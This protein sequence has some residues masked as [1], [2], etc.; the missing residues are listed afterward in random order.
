MAEKKTEIAEDQ[1]Q[2]NPVVDEFLL[3]EQEAGL[4]IEIPDVEDPDSLGVGGGEYVPRLTV[5]AKDN[6]YYITKSYGGLNECILGSP[7]YS[8]GSALNNCVGYAWGR[9]YELLG[10][11]PKL[12]RANAEDWW[13]Y[14]DG[15]KRGQVPKLGAIACWRKGKAG[16][17]ADGAGHVAVCEVIEG[18]NWKAGQSGYGASTTFWLTTYKTGSESHGAYVFQGFIYIDDWEEKPVDPPAPS[19]DLK[20][21]DIVSFTGTKHYSSAN[22]TKAATTKPGPAKVTQL[23]PSGKH[24][25][26]LIHTDSTSN[27]YGWVDKADIAGQATPTPEPWTPKVG[28]VVIYN[29]VTHYTNANAAN[30]KRCKG[31]KAV[32]SRIYKLGQSK[33]PYLL[34][35]VAGSGATVYGWVDTGTFTKA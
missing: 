11:R 2:T 15:Y 19:A 3:S 31:G 20:V 32:I 22:A 4:E 33:H 26:H 17:G 34:I 6:K 10:S 13:G 29:G 8:K 30:P 18:G 25:V 1:L 21:G 24:P 16:Y 28:D 7:Q 35:R 23:Y 9:A 14:N 5:P 27:V 12:S